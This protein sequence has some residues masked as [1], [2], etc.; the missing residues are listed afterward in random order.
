MTRYPMAE[1][2]ETPDGINQTSLRGRHQKKEK[3]TNSDKVNRTRD[4]LEEGLMKVRD[5][6]TYFNCLENSS[7]I[8][9][10]SQDS[11]QSAEFPAWPPLAAVVVVVAAVEV[12][13]ISV[14]SCVQS[15]FSLSLVSHQ[16]DGEKERVADCWCESKKR[17]KGG[18][19]RS[20]PVKEIRGK[21]WG[22]IG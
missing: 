8:S 10:S 11:S 17:G 7:L 14:S 2:H 19:E 16:P 12:V 4:I 21:R 9:S 3:E 20:P 18:E 22:F 5:T 15:V 1:A 6:E 13:D